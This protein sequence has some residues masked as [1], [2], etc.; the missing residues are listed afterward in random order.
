MIDSFSSRRTVRSA[1]NYSLSIF[2]SYTSQARNSTTDTPPSKTRP[3]A[4]AY[5]APAAFKS[6]LDS[7]LALSTTP[8]LPKSAREVA[9][10]AVGVYY[11]SAYEVY[12]HERLAHAA[13]VS[14]RQISHVKLGRKPPAD[15]PDAFDEA[16][17]VAWDVAQDLMK[18]RG[19]MGDGL[20]ERAVACFGKEG[21][22]GLV[23]Y[24]GYYTYCCFLINGD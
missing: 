24:V 3:I 4:T 9:I 18:A 22:L 17:E 2:V 13:G 15:G 11:N 21:A 14:W 19:R 8:N 10:L 5:A 12:A 16:C 23:H 20:W 6:F 7:A 1:G